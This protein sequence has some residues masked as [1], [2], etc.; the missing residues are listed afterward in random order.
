MYGA[1][2]HQVK[3]NLLPLPPS[4]FLWPTCWGLPGCPRSSTLSQGHGGPPLSSSPHKPAG[5]QVIS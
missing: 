1:W 3:G 5:V 4:D 2:T